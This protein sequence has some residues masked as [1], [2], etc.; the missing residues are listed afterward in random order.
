MNVTSPDQRV[1]TLNIECTVTALSDD[2]A[3]AIFNVAANR[4]LYIDK[5]HALTGSLLSNI[6][7]MDEG[8]HEIHREAR[9]SDYFKIEGSHSMDE[10]DNRWIK[11]EELKHKKTQESTESITLLARPVSNPVDTENVTDVLNS[12]SAP[13]VTFKVI[14]R[15]LNVTAAMYGRN[16]TQNT[17]SDFAFDKVE[18]ASAALAIGGCLMQWRSLVYSMLDNLN[19]V[20]K[21]CV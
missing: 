18:H 12:N 14:R 20:E 3:S 17:G 16:E 7:L 11:V 4:L 2:F 15:G 13:G 21:F 8:G 6:K 5:W 9:Q 10:D 19:E 1:K